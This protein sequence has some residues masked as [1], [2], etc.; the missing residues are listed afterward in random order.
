M[1][2][3]SEFDGGLPVGTTMQFEGMGP[4]ESLWLLKDGRTLARAL[5]ENG[6]LSAIFPV[7]KLTGTLRTLAA[8]PTAP[9][10]ALATAT[11]F[12]AA[13][14][15]GT[16]GLQYSTDGASWATATIGSAAVVGI[17]E[18][19]TRLIIISSGANAPQVSANLSPTSAWSNTT[20]GPA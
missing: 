1:L 20:S 3:T 17:L 15:S 13:A 6:P 8:I 16:T 9:A 4:P 19:A 11:H 7:G 12:L 18:T 2:Y 5:A 14:T 10:V